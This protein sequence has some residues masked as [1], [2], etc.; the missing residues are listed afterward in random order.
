MSNYTHAQESGITEMWIT[1]GCQWRTELGGRFLAMEDGEDSMAG[2]SQLTYLAES[3]AETSTECSRQLAT[4]TKK[5]ARGQSK[6]SRREQ[7][8]VQK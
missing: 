3:S 7:Q 1:R 8:R 6:R 5:K 4:L 2:P